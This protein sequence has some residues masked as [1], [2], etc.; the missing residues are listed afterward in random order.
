MKFMLNGAVTLGTYD[1][2]NIEI[3]ERAGEE[4]N[5][6]FGARVEDIRK[7]QNSYNPKSLY[8][9]DAKIRRCLDA[10]V[11]GTL[12]DNNTGIFEELYNSLLRVLRGIRLIII[13][14]FLI[15]NLFSMKT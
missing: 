5:Y 6:I 15:L 7:I 10:L 14:S 2:A 12:S 4:N 9:N 1:G 3:V 8:E 13:I 11:D